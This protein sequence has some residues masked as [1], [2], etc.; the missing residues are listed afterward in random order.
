MALTD[1]ELGR[2]KAMLGTDYVPHL[3]ALLPNKNTAQDQATKNLSRAFSAFVLAN[4]CHLAPA[5]AA[6]MVVDDFNDRGIDAI[7]FHAPDQTLYLVQV[8][9]KSGSEFQEPEAQSFVSGIRQFISGDFANFNTHVQNRKLELEGALDTC[10]HVKVVVAYVGERVSHNARSELDRLTGDLNQDEQRYV[11][12]FIEIGPGHVLQAMD[13]EKAY[14]KIDAKLKI[15]KC[16]KISEPRVTFIGTVWLQD[17]VALHDSYQDA[18]FAENIRNPLGVKSDVNDSIRKTLEGS[19]EHFFYMNNGITILAANIAP[20]K[21][22]NDGEQ[23]LDLRGLS[24]INGAQTIATAAAFKAAQPGADISRAKVTITLIAADAN[25]EFG[26]SVTHA[27]NH[28]NPVSGEDFAAL[29]DNQERLR[30]EI[31]ARSLRYIY[32]SGDPAALDDPDA[33]GIVEAAYSLALLDEHPRTVWLLKAKPEIFRTLGS[34][35]YQRVFSRGLTAETLINAVRVAR[36]LNKFMQEAV[37]DET[38]Q[39]AKETLRHASVTHGWVLTKRTRDQI[40]GAVLLD[41][42]KVG[43]Q[44]GSPADTLRQSIVDITAA[45]MR[46]ASARAWALYRNQATSLELLEAIMIAHYGTTNPAAIVAKKSERPVRTNSRGR[47]VPLFD[48]PKSLF[49]YLCAKAPQIGNLS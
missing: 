48:Y 36:Y 15:M 37:R 35:E 18:L 7:Y 21:A 11:H 14:R 47:A 49:D 43:A 44:L 40:N 31:A 25:G 41:T 13:L 20:K 17:L 27:R 9:L 29:D 3:P 30:R 39:V 1:A 24:V 38:D 19:P 23:T 22:A 45:R 46:A 28:Q 42:V 34:P 4:L 16:R 10:D 33:I 8:K 12:P 6:G 26:K 32:K 5:V 2:L